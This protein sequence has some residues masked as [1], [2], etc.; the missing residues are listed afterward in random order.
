MIVS[1]VDPSGQGVKQARGRVRPGLVVKSVQGRS[2]SGMKAK[3][4]I[5]AL[6]T[7][8]QA[9][10]DPQGLSEVSLGELGYGWIRLD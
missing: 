3:D 1:S 10:S 6:T 7:E 2:L 8:V 4:A 5:Q 9:R